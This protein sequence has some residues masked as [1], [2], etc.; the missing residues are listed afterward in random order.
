VELIEQP[1][2]HS[3]PIGRLVEVLGNYA[4]PGMEIEIALRKHEMPHE[5]SGERW[6]RRASC[7]MQCASRTGRTGRHHQ[8]ALVTIDGETA[9][10]FDDAVYCER[11]GKGYRLVVAIADVSHYVTVGSALDKEPLSAATRCISRAA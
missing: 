1:S 5:F 2:K 11:R 6:R 7:P 10:D 3:Q 8:S 4:D 9:R